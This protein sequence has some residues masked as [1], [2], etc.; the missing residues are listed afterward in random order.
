M[1]TTYDD[2]LYARTTNFKG[3]KIKVTGWRTPY[4]W[5]VKAESR[6]G[7]VTVSDSTSKSCFKQ[8]LKSLRMNI[9]LWS[10]PNYGII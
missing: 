6:Y 5:T 7:S 1:K 4:F 2:G 3:I 10:N 9:P 8:A